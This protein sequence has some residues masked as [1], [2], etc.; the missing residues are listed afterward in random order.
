[1]ITRILIT[2]KNKDIPRWFVCRACEGTGHDWATGNNPS[3]RPFKVKCTVC[4]GDG[5][6]KKECAA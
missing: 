6:Y 3:E 5:A 4:N 1:M 2:G